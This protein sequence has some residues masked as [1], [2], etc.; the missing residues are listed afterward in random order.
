MSADTQALVLRAHPFTQDT[1]VYRVT[2]GHTLQQMLDEAAGGHQLRETLRV[3]VGGYEVPRELWG[4]V[5][6]KAGAAIH[7]TGMPAGGGSGGKILRTVLLIA[8][9][10]VAMWATG[11]GAAGFLGSAFAAG[12]TGAAVLGAGLY[13]VGTLIVNAL[14]PPPKP[15]S[16]GGQGGADPGRLNMLTGSSNQVAPYGPI[17]LVLGECKVFPPHAAMPYSETIGSTSYQRLLFDLGY[18]DLDV[19]DIRIGDSPLSAFEDVEYEI[20]TTPTLYTDDVSE[21]NVSAQM[22]DGDSAVRT[23]APDVDEISLDVVFP[24]GLFGMDKKGNIV[25]AVAN[26]T[27]EYRA[28]GASTWIRAPQ[29]GTATGGVV[30]RVVGLSWMGGSIPVQA[31]TA[32][33]KPFAAAYG[34]GVAKGQYEVRVT[35]SATNWNG[36]ET[37]SRIGDATWSVLRSIRHTNPSRTGTTKLCMRIK[38]S[39]QLN[40]TLQTLSCVVHQK[41]P[42]YNPGTGSWSAPQLNRNPAW[43]YHWLLTSCPAL[44]VHVPSERVDLEAIAAYAAFC[45]EHDFE[46]RGVLDARTTAR[47]LI[48]DV[49]ACALGAV[50]M[51]DGKYGVLFDS[52]E[53]TPTMVFTPLDTK[54]FGVSRVFTRLPHALKVKFRNP[55]ANWEPDEIMVLDDEHS[56]RGKNARGVASALP[57]PTEFESIELR[58]AADPHQAWRVGRH[59]FAQAKFRPNT[60]NWETDIA[61]LG[62]VRGD[63]VH[64]AHDVTEWGA[65][66]GRIKSISGTSMQ[67]DEVIELPSGSSYSARIRKQDGSSV[68]VGVT[69]AGT[70][71]ASFTLVAAQSGVHPGDV[72]V[73]GE[74]GQETRKL[75]VTG[76]MPGADLSARLSAVEYDSRVAPYWANPPA[77]IVSE[78]TGTAYTDPPEPPNIFVIIS[79]QRNDQPDDGGSTR[80]EVHIGVRPPSGYRPPSAPWRGTR[81]ATQ[82][83]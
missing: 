59:H 50:T 22:N 64:V 49:L 5:R 71:T 48:D 16:M 33:R 39:E 76:V 27:V 1:G 43:V 55:S 45:T 42:V 6:P 82:A 37:N 11:G 57:E 51:R 44:S 74:T 15:A 53:T 47:A 17:P 67:L 18:G 29:P 32:D 20:T 68:V 73:I 35:R 78:I 26:V 46:V 25:S 69:P 12:T 65:G 80:P 14:V 8:V 7:V 3:E 54:G 28:V 58:M 23:T 52:G 34:W 81:V 70:E 40:G 21:T 63:V 61:N 19:T 77:V 66:W 38:A 75:L 10:V 56:Y 4:R 41:I 13:M 24:Q 9:A 60:Y 62:C 79:S 36:A 83:L 2:A 31:R 30:S 72:V